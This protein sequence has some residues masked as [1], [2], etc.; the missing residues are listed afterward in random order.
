MPAGPAALALATGAALVPVTLWFPED[1]RPG[2]Q[3]QFHP[4][5]PRP[6]TGTRTEQVGAMTQ[7]MANEF[8]SSIA[9][10]PADWH[11]V[12]RLWVADLDPA[13]DAL[14]TGAAA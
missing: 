11:M 2:W 12:Q 13:R 9:A 4:E 7:A 3:G 6:T 1:G 5:V 10:H 14:R 8:A